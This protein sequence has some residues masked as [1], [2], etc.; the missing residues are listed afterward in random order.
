VLPIPE[1][2]HLYIIQMY[3][4]HSKMS[5]YNVVSIVRRSHVGE[6]GL[7]LRVDVRFIIG[8]HLLGVLFVTENRG[9]CPF[10][11]SYLQL[12]PAVR[13]YCLAMD[14]FITTLEVSPNGT[15][16]KLV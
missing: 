8:E 11:L 9:T 4:L 3:Y 13:D 10:V 5:L 7:K 16:M 15:E 12:L 14:A 6:I 2:I 1:V